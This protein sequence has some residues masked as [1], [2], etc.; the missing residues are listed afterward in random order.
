MLLSSAWAKW[1]RAEVHRARFTELER[2]YASEIGDPAMVVK[3]PDGW[4]EYRRRDLPGPPI[5]VSLV[6]GECLQAYR[7]ALEHAVYALSKAADPTFE[8]SEFPIALTE[9]DFNRKRQKLRHVPLAHQAFVARLQPYAT[10]TSDPKKDT[11]WLLHDLAR[12]DR[13]RTIPLTTAVAFPQSVVT[14]TRLTDEVQQSEVEWVLDDG[15]IKP[16]GLLLRVPPSSSPFMTTTPNW[17]IVIAEPM[18]GQWIE[19]L[20]SPMSLLVA[21]VIGELETDDPTWPPRQDYRTA[22]VSGG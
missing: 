17:D 8:S 22:H 10:P 9:A 6:L 1:R 19:P 13:H 20:L 4:T 7:S 16:G 18:S 21:L 12:I 14:A 5:E 3:T 11:L 2:E 15:F